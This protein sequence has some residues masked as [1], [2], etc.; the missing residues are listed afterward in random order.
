VFFFHTVSLG[1]EHWQDFTDSSAWVVF[2][3]ILSKGH[4][5]VALFFVLSGFLITYLLLHEAKWRGKVD[6]LRFFMRRLL[7]IWPLYF[8]VVLFGFL[9]FPHLPFGI[10]TSNSLSFYAGFLSNFEEIRNGWQDPVSFL[11]VTWSVSIEE[12]FYLSWVALIALLP[13][14]ARGKYFQYYFL[15][16]LGVS[17]AFRFH[18]MDA[19]RMIYFHTLSVVS[20][21]ALGGLLAWRAFHHGISE[22]FKALAGWKITLVYVLGIG[23]ILGDTLLFRGKMIVIERLVLGLFFAFVIAEQV[24]CRHSFFKADRIPGFKK[25]G[26]IS[27]GWYMYHCIVLYFV[28]QVLI[29]GGWIHSALDFGLFVLLAFAFT[30]LISWCSYRFLEEPMLRLKRFFR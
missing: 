1:R 11:S 25:L 22:R 14:F 23:M 4:H 21:L 28:Q 20:D 24:Y 15:L 13:F 6:P 5:G 7:R 3:K 2:S 29:Q 26:E 30:F 27:Y 10:E 19:E 8:T 9:L 17:L 12:Q 16:L 18:Y